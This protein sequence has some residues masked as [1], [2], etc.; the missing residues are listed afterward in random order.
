MLRCP[1][2][3]QQGGLPKAAF[4]VRC[5]LPA[6]LRP[7]TK[8]EAH[9]ADLEA[10]AASGRT[11]EQRFEAVQRQCD[12]AVQAARQVQAQLRAQEEACE[13]LQVRGCCEHQSAATQRPS[14]C[15]NCPWHGPWQRTA[16]RGT[17]FWPISIGET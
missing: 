1:L 3:W 14:K 17:R 12:E 15:R 2:P 9:L 11:A 5:Y 13:E 8:L 10:A 16:Q 4:H 6:L 7:Q